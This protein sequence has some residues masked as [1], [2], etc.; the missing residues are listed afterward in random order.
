MA[1]CAKSCQL[2]YYVR[3]N[4]IGLPKRRPKH[5]RWD[6]KRRKLWSL[7]ILQIYFRCSPR[8]QIL[9]SSNTFFLTFNHRVEERCGQKVKSRRREPFE[10]REDF[11]VFR[12]D[13]GSRL[14]FHP[15]WGLSEAG[16][17]KS[18]VAISWDAKQ[19]S[20]C[21]TQWMGGEKKSIFGPAQRERKRDRS[22]PAIYKKVR[23]GTEVWFRENLDLFNDLLFCKSVSQGGIRWY[24]QK[25]WE[26][27]EWGGKKKSFLFLSGT[28]SELEQLLL[29]CSMFH[30]P[31]SKLMPIWIIFWELLIRQPGGMNCWSK[32]RKWTWSEFPGVL[33]WQWS[34][35]VVKALS[36][37]DG[38]TGSIPAMTLMLL[39]RE[40]PWTWIVSFENS[41]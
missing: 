9:V 41:I 26:Q 4:C 39:E 17:K 7:K 32:T 37:P 16:R 20:H 1:T 33:R 40:N 6:W 19:F 23:L 30:G 38:F 28:V 22:G 36:T 8:Q 18:Q 10:F 27:A 15:M 24:S 2:G 13:N 12:I 5:D 21:L 29:D 35:H 11:N 25:N 3:A 31:R 14:T 34:K